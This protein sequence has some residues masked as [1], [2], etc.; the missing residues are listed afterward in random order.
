[1][2]VNLARRLFLYLTILLVAVC[3]AHSQKSGA[4]SFAQDEKQKTVSYSFVSPNTRENLTLEEAFRMLNSKEETELVNY[5][6]RLSVCLKL[7]PMVSKAIGNWIDGA[8]HS[9]ISRVYTDRSTLLYEDARLGALQRQKTILYFRKKSSGE[10]R[11]YILSTRRGRRSLASISKSL[12]KS[13]VAFRTLVPASHH[14]TII[15]VVDLKGELQSKVRVAARRLG[16]RLAIVK[17][18]GEFVGDDA[19]REKAQQV[20]AGIIKDYEDE[21]PQ[22]GRQCSLAK[23]H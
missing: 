5:L 17:G 12:D 13:G 15:Y 14:R 8:E 16:S 19:D 10:G 7:N 3:S 1:M 4:Q 23:V 18:T 9:T 2:R 11:M 6:Q 21:H 22:V 20:F